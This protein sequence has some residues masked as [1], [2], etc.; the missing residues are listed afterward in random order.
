M[1]FWLVVYSY[2][3]GAAVPFLLLAFLH[4]VPWEKILGHR[5]PRLVAYAFGVVAIVTGV[6]VWTVVSILSGRGS[7]AVWEPLVAVVVMVAAA[8]TATLGSYVVDY[9][10]EGRAALR[11]LEEAL[12]GR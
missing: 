10:L 7:V 4:Y 9:L 2:V 3:L 8:G 1:R 5:L 12:H 6:G 11:T